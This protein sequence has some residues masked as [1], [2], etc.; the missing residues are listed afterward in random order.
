MD[1][2]KKRI[3][4]FL[5]YF[6]DIMYQNSLDRLTLDN[7]YGELIRLGVPNT[8]RNEKI[9]D[10]FKNWIMHFQNNPNCNVFVDPKWSYFCQFIS[11]DNLARNSDEHLKI[12]IPLDLE[13]IDRGAKEIFEFLSN[14]NISHVSKIGSHIRFD[15]I[16]VRLINP[17][18]VKK[19]IEFINK[20]KYIQ[21]GLLPANPFLYNVNGI[22]MAVDGRL[23]FNST[24]ASLIAIYINEKTEI[25]RLDTVEVNDFYDFLQS[26]YNK[27][28][29]SAKGLQKLENDFSENK[30]LSAEELVNYKNVI[31]LILKSN[32]ENFNFENYVAHY[33]SCSNSVINNYKINQ[34]KNIKKLNIHNFENNDIVKK[35]NEML[36]E[37][38]DGMMI[39]NKDTYAVLC[40]INNYY[41]S[42]QEN[43]ITRDNNLREKVVNSNFR[44]ELKIVLENKNVNCIEYSELL[45]SQRKNKNIM[46]SQSYST[47]EKK[48]ILTSK[49]ILDIMFQKGG[50][51]F[52]QGNFIGYI[53]TGNPNLL[54]REFDLRNRISNSTFRMDLINLL[55]MKKIKLEDYLNIVF[56]M[57]VEYNEVYLEQAILETYFKYEKKYQN[58]FSNISGKEF[59]VKSLY[60]LIKTGTYIG[61]T[62][63]N[64]ARKNLENNV[65]PN[66]V[67]DIIRNSFTIE[68][69]KELNSSN[70]NN[71]LEEY[72]DIVLQNNNIKRI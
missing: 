61:F 4:E 71:L 27:V 72:I 50:R 11:K 16:V 65:S 19:V 56:G 40:A 22:P 34:I 28:F 69:F 67:L 25:N 35:T 2:R 24:I 70:I 3:D 31:E 66:E 49:E 36:L 63:D 5:K 20:N 58:G 38:I 21:E 43:Y 54:T 9:N 18:D 32:K 7:V 6:R 1:D 30:Y 26:Y 10:N 64:D 68:K 46:Q 48:I 29:F 47:I 51:A 59:V 45:L 60:N 52:A 62:R 42:G 15:D 57:T 44:E 12:Y 14:N 39:K 41:I 53:N 8:E 23:S 13:H 37:L 17:S 33:N 55:N